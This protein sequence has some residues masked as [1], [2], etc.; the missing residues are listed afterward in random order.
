MERNLSKHQKLLAD[1][2]RLKDAIDTLSS[3]LLSHTI[4]LPGK[5][6]DVLDDM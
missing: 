3:G 4:I 6:A 5:L 2:D 1:L